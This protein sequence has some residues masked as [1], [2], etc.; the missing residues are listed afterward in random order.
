MLQDRVQELL[1]GLDD[2][3]VNSL[4][5]S[6]RIKEADPLPDLPTLTDICTPTYIGPTWQ[7][8]ETGWKLPEKTLGW[9]LAAWCST[10]L[11][12]PQDSSKPWEFTPEQLRFFLHWYAVDERGK[13]PARRGVLQRLKGWGKDPI[14]AVICLVEALAPCRFSHWD[15]FGLPVGRQETSPLVQVAA[16]TQDQTANTGDMFPLLL[17]DKAIKE[18]GIQLG[19]EL[20]RARDKRAKIQMITSNPRAIEG[21]RSTFV[22]LNEVHQWVS[23][24]GGPA[25]YQA[26]SRNMTKIPGARFLA[27]TNAYMPGENSVGEMLRND[28]EK[29]GIGGRS[30]SLLYDSVEADP[31]APILGPMVPLVVE[32]VRGDAKWLDIEAIQDEMSYESI[33]ISVNRRFWL[34]QIVTSDDRIYGPEDWDHLGSL[35]NILR[36]GERIALGFDGSKSDDATALVAIRLKD[37]CVFPLGIWEP[38]RKRREEKSIVPY[39]EVDEAVRQAMNLYDVHAF[40]ADVAGWEPYIHEWTLDYAENMGVKASER[41]PIGLDMRGNQARIVSSNE[42]LITAIRHGKIKHDGDSTLR[43]HVF[44]VCYSISRFGMSFRKENAESPHKI[45]AYAAML[46]AFMAASDASIRSKK[47]SEVRKGRTFLMG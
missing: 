12:N 8:D 10:Y 23:A 7:T 13:P 16:V 46:L 41:S 3:G 20:I 27:I 19:S 1:D 6:L 15:S 17:T 40:Y 42:A 45:D 34:N 2:E 37:M 43:R 18:Y 29:A 32:G 28:Y 38:D 44:N 47:T 9:E 22:V 11:M 30:K 25:M 33:D 24:N 21:K 31:R 14:V 35:D 39:S 26:I 4:K 36:R 5:R